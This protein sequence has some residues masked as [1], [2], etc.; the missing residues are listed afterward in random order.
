MP[1]VPS[2]VS[3]RRRL[4]AHGESVSPLFLSWA[5]LLVSVF[6]VLILTFQQNGCWLP[7]DYHRVPRP[8]AYIHQ[9]GANKAL[10]NQMAQ[11]STVVADVAEQVAPSVVNIDVRSES[12]PIALKRDG[13]GEAPLPELPDFPG[14]EWLR[15]FLGDPFQ[16]EGG[17]S[18]EEFRALPRTGS[19]TGVVF[20]PR[21]FI[22]TNYHV[23]AHADEVM[24]TLHTGKKYPATVVGTDVTTDLAVIK[25]V[26]SPPLQAAKLGDSDAM[27]P[28]EWVIAVGSPLGFDHTVTFG[29]ISA[30][31]RQVPSINSN[32]EFIQTDAAINP[33][34][35]GGPLINL[36]GEV[37]GINT[38]IA[39]HGQGIGF[40][41]PSR[42]VDEVATALVKQ[43]KVARSMV[44]MTMGPLTPERRAGLGLPL[45]A[46]GVLVVEVIA[47]TPAKEAGLL[48][49]DL[50]QAIDGQPVDDPKKVR[51]L[52]KARPIGSKVVMSL[53][54]HNQPQTLT[55]VT[56]SLSEQQIEASQHH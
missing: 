52:I 51:A 21:G 22:L 20:D 43:G 28:G 23:V 5:A 19:G 29:I 6:S 11:F 49:G 36:N 7:E 30:Q 42:V 2:S 50:I 47:D 4:A 32:V 48:A 37:I 17:L 18:P 10:A 45:D 14:R 8:G 35:S 54:R 12:G 44:G 39:G 9:G 27:R 46:K 40:A 3:R 25:L 34:N 41:I 24:V 38:A 53:L 56:R 15:R 16:E 13:S 26:E 55:M 33:G 31:A 1:T